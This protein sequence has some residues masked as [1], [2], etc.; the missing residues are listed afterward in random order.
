MT[1]GT[2]DKVEGC[3][4]YEL[5]KENNKLEKPYYKAENTTIYA[6]GTSSAAY[7]VAA[8]NLRTDFLD[9]GKIYDKNNEE[10][11]GWKVSENA[12]PIDLTCTKVNVAS[13]ENANNVV[14][15]E[16]YNKF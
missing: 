5:W 12:I 4:Y 11:S 2:E 6:Q 10:V 13:C 8:F 16:W 1:K 15:Q 3:T 14:N 9:K 7:G